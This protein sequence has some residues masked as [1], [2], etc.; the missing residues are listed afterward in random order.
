MATEARTTAPRTGAPTYCLAV[1]RNGTL[2]A[3]TFDS[4]GQWSTL[5]PQQVGI[6]DSPAMVRY[7][8][9]TYCLHQGSPG[10]RRLW[11]CEVTWSPGTSPSLTFH[12]DLRVVPEVFMTNSPAATVYRGRLYC[13]YR[14]PDAEGGLLSHLMF[15]GRQWTIP[16]T[17]Y[18]DIP[19]TDSPALVVYQDRLYCLYRRF[20]GW[21]HQTSFDG[22]RWEGDRSSAAPVTANPG[23]AVYDDKLYL[24]RQERRQGWL[25]CR[26]FD[27]FG[28]SP[29]QAPDVGLANSPA[30]V[31]VSGGPKDLLYCLHQGRSGDGV[32]C[33][34]FDGLGWARDTKVFDANLSASPGVGRLA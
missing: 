15:D 19:I 22:E 4:D 21:L 33:T 7:L 10:D 29:D 14:G 3:A 2:S 30:A 13:A 27:G 18:P 5:Q 28:W 17:S 1:N 26:F 31:V 32:W 12:D 16:K 24:L 11:F 6:T 20:D 8:G 34:R 25:L 9:R 23:V